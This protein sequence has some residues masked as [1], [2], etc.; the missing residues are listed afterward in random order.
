M[1]L[2]LLLEA[3]LVG[4]APGV[5]WPN[6]GA[7]ITLRKVILINSHHALLQPQVKEWPWTYWTHLVTNL[8][9][10]YYAINTFTTHLTYINHFLKNSKIPFGPLCYPS[11]SLIQHL[12]LL[13]DCGLC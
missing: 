1:L 4:A 3:L 2:L 7:D 13:V 11:F 10:F 8:L 6:S 9:V 5:L 12:V